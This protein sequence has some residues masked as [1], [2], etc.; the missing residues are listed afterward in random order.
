MQTSGQTVVTDYATLR[1]DQTL[2]TRG[3]LRVKSALGYGRNDFGD[4]GPLKGRT[5]NYLRATLDVA[6]SFK[7]WLTA[8]IGYEFEK[9]MTASRLN[10]DYSVNRVTLSL[11]I[12]Y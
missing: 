2:G 10:V 7:L 9:L 6:Y 8:G 5:D 12:G 11:S 1:L 3:R 4:S